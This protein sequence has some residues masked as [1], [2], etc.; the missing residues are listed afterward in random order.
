MKPATHSS[1]NEVLVMLEPA[2][3]EPITHGQREAWERLVDA[4]R[5]AISHTVQLDAP[6]DAL[7]EITAHAQVLSSMLSRFSGA[8]PVPRFQMPFDPASPQSY[9]PYSPVAGALNPLAPPVALT[10]EDDRLVGRVVL[11]AAYEGGVGFAHGGVVALIWDQVLA[12]ANLAKGMAGPTGEL[13]VRYLAPTPIGQE[14]RF[15]A[16]HER[17]EGR[18]I[19]AL[20]R[21]Y[22]GSVVVSEAEG[23][24]VALD[25]SSKRR[26]GW[27]AHS[28]AVGTLPERLRAGGKP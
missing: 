22:A 11:G 3:V 13:R 7:E 25:A 5:Q 4:L 21:C 12:L 16:W 27:G 23:V 19:V 18:R 2:A 8:K 14:L 20:G 17:R 6:L 9:L 28:Q 1:K 26:T 15:E 10:V 24:F